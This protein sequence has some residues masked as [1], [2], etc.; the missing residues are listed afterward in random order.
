MLLAQDVYDTF[1]NQMPSIFFLES[2]IRN[3]IVFIL[4]NT[5]HLHF[6]SNLQQCKYSR[7]GSLFK[8]TTM[9]SH[10]CMQTIQYSNPDKVKTC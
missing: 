9:D 3:L 8:R 10:A 2:V 1:T 4:L 5:A 7:I 6:P